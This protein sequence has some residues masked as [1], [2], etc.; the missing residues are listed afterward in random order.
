MEVTSGGIIGQFPFEVPEARVHLF[1]TL[2]EMKER[3]N[4]SPFLKV[5][6]SRKGYALAGRRK[7]ENRGASDTLLS[8]LHP[9]FFTSS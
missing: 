6:L 8:P 5:S 4:G 1:R 3:A 9:D 7:I 2:L